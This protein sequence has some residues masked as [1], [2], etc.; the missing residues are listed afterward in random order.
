MHP[1]DAIVETMTRLYENKMTTTSGGNLSIMDDNGTLWISPSGVD[2]AHLRRSDIMSVLPDGTV[3]GIHKVSTECPFHLA[4]RRSRP[5]L[6]AVLH[7]HPGALVAF[8]LMRKIP[9]TSIIPGV[10]G[11]CG[12]ITMAKYALPGSDLLGSYIAEEFAKG[13]NTVMLENHGV[14]IGAESLDRAFMMFESLEYCARIQ[15][16]AAALNSGCRSLSAE[17]LKKVDEYRAYPDTLPQSVPSLEEIDARNELINLIRRSSIH[18]FFSFSTGVLAASLPDGSFVITPHDDGRIKLEADDL[19]R[20]KDGKCEKG[21]EPSH[22]TGLTERIFKAHPEIKSIVIAR[23]PEI[24]GFAVGDAEFDS[25]L[26]P[27]SYICLKEIFRYKF[28]TIEDNPDAIIKAISLKNPIAIVENDVVIVAGSTAL[29]AFDRLEVME[30]GA[31]SLRQ[32]K[33]F[34]GNIVR[35]SD[36]EVREIEVAFKL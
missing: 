27:E 26:I 5:E 13:Y 30:F 17:Q 19:V 2:K 12:K 14:V 22:F 33:I 23:P 32:I 20:V 29:N 8:S 6:K 28:G 9:D 35:I 16:N 10:A 3:R 36:D 4:I 31:Y 34:G 15:L 1:A 24:M 11:L 7:A 25:R 21:K 18:K